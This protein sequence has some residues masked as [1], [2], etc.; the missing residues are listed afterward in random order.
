MLRRFYLV[1]QSYKTITQKLVS[2]WAVKGLI[3]KARLL[4]K[5]KTKKTKKK[6]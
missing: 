5:K 3:R 1:S 6:T 4:L 2:Q